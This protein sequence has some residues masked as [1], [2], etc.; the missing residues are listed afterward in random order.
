[1]GPIAGVMGSSGNDGYDDLFI[2]HNSDD[3]IAVLDGGPNGLALTN[4]S[5][6]G[7][8]GTTDGPGCLERRI[9]VTSI[10]T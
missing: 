9:R 6:P 1:M 4:T 7:S 10:F 3:W 8:L 5:V 2:A